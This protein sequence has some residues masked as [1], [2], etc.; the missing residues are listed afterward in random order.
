MANNNFLD[1]IKQFSKRNLKPTE[2]KI[3]YANGRQ[4]VKRSD[5]EREIEV[6]SNGQQ[7]TNED[8]NEFWSQQLGFVVDIKKDLKCDQILDRLYLSSEDVALD[9]E[10]LAKHNITHILNLT[11][12][13]PNKFEHEII[14]KK[15]LIYDLPNQ[16]MKSIFEESFEFI[17][18]ALGKSPDSNMLVHCNAGVSRSSTVV[19]A[20]LLKKRLFASLNETYDHVKARRPAIC[21]N[22]GFV[23]Q[24]KEL[25]AALNSS[26]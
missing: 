5:D 10:L 17:D 23:R 8:S 6:E 19:I 4:F 2:T 14:Y 21:P 12:N 9:R 22:P 3:W 16:S 13:V 26:T 11:T 20:Y 1:Q 25:E 15:L 7:S 18:E 24:L